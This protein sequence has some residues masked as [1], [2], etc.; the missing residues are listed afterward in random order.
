MSMM[1]M[2]PVHSARYYDDEQACCWE[3]R[4]LG[5]STRALR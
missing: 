3:A 5:R 2:R 1:G 4:P